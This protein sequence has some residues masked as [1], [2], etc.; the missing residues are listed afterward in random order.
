[1]ATL[2][3]FPSIFNFIKFYAFYLFKLEVSSFK[4]LDESAIKKDLLNAGLFIVCKISKLNLE[5]K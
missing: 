1:L 5:A 3:K 2:I 4:N